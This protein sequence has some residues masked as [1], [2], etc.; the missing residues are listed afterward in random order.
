MTRYSELLL[1]HQ[2]AAGHFKPAKLRQIRHAEQIFR[3]RVVGQ[4]QRIDIAHHKSA[5]IDRHVSEWIAAHQAD[6]DSWLAAARAD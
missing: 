5:D 3:Q 2:L 4:H 6:Y 1:H